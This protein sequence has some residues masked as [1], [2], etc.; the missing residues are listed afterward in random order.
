MDN[1]IQSKPCTAMFV[2]QEWI[3]FISQDHE[4]STRFRGHNVSYKYTRYGVYSS[5]PW[6]QGNFKTNLNLNKW[7]FF[8]GQFTSN[9]TVARM[10]LYIV[11]EGVG[12]TNQHFTFKVI[13]YRSCTHHLRYPTWFCI[14]GIYIQCTHILLLLMKIDVCKIY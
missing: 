6:S 7:I 9:I 14:L 5:T 3:R 4:L 10:Q 8:G 12:R 2:S 13:G 11:M 1:Y